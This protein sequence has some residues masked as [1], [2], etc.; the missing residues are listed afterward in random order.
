MLDEIRQ[1]TFAAPR[2]ADFDADRNDDRAQHVASAFD[3]AHGP[4]IANAGECL[5]H[6]LVRE[7]FARNEREELLRNEETIAAQVRSAMRGTTVPR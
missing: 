2:F 6:E 3:R 5:V 7:V 4:R 1:S